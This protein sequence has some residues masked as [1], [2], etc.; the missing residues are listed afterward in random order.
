MADKIV[1]GGMILVGSGNQ[2]KLIKNGAIYIENGEIKDIGKYQDLNRSYKCEE[3]IGSNK[4]L[5]IPG[6]INSHHH[7]RGISQ[8]QMGIKDAP[9]EYWM[10]YHLGGVYDL[11]VYNNTLLSCIQQIE[12]GITT[13]LHHFYV[14]DPLYIDD[15]EKDVENII[16][17]HLDSGMR[18]SLAPSIRNQHK[19]VYLDEENF[20]SKLPSRII[21]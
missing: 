15:Y 7:G 8:L 10:T 3:T 12:S 4:F 6:F 11:Q 13:S 20:I 5:V 14:N 1:Y 19:F 9:L 21:N 16:K 2:R 17:A 18:V